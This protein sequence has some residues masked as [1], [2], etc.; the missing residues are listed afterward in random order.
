[1]TCREEL[2]SLPVSERIAVIIEKSELDQE[3]FAL[4]LE[5]RRETVNRWV[6]GHDKPGMPYRR[7]LAK[8]ATEIC[9]EPISADFFRERPAARSADEVLT[10]ILQSNQVSA[11]ATRTLVGLLAEQRAVVA[12]LTNLGETLTAVVEQLSR[13]A[14]LLEQTE[15]APEGHAG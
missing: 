12:T 11:E 5:T 6:R 9:G 3:E 1:M 4:R 14:Q 10:Q 7:K 2:A 13:I 8:L 15:A